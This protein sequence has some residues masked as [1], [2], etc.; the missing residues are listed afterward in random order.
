MLS[1]SGPIGG[2]GGGG[3][4]VLA[5]RTDDD[6]IAIFLLRLGVETSDICSLL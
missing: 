3:G 1:V 4:G 2:G 6:S 5:L